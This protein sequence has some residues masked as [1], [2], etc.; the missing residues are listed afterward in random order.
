MNNRF[1][2]IIK[3]AKGESLSSVEINTIKDTIRKRMDAVPLPTNLKNNIIS[4]SSRGAVP[5]PFLKFFRNPRALAL[6]FAVFI[7]CAGGTYAASESSLPG[8]NL[9]PVKIAGEAV[10]AAFAVGFQ[11]NASVQADQALERVKEAE[12]LSA[13]NRLDPATS[14][15]LQVSFLEHSKSS[16]ENIDNMK[17]S[18]DDTS[19]ALTTN[20]KNNLTAHQDILTHLKV[21]MTDSARAAVNMPSFASSVDA[22]LKGLDVLGATTSAAVNAVLSPQIPSHDASYNVEDKNEVK[23]NNGVVGETVQT[24]TEVNNAPVENGQSV[25][26]NSSAN[27]NT[28]VNVGN[29]MQAGASVNTSNTSNSSNNTSNNSSGAVN[30]SVEVKLPPPAAA[31]GEVATPVVKGLGL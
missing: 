28:N 6:A 2:D 25:N 3:A 9:Y 26:T 29:T 1:E 11:S 10:R 31:V 15:E 24:H 18:G 4:H 23:Q 19:Y 22:V 5:S 21:I 7:I 20:F 17:Q 27:V 13:E 16:L 30:A 12:A 8:D 14:N